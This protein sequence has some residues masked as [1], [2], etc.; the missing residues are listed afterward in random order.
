MSSVLPTMTGENTLQVKLPVSDVPVVYGQHQTININSHGLTASQ[1][2][3]LNMDNGTYVT[4]SSAN[5]SIGSDG[6]TT[7]KASQMFLGNFETTSFSSSAIGEG[8]IQTTNLS[9]M[10]FG[11]TT[12]ENGSLL[13]IDAK[14][15]SAEVICCNDK[16]SCSFCTPDCFNAIAE[17]FSS[18]AACCGSG[19][20]SLLECIGN[21]IK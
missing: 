9:N 7:S 2:G 11:N 18:F 6:I 10:T 17:C 13:E 20:C 21:V 14:G 15:I 12:I 1:S 8:G 16:E 5:S 3:F 19:C 4:V